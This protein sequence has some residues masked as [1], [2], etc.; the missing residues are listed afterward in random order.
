MAS[1][2][3]GEQLEPL[4]LSVQ[5]EMHVQLVAQPIAA[6]QRRSL[7]STGS[8]GAQGAGG[9][10]QNPG[11]PAAAEVSLMPTEAPEQE[12]T[13]SPAEPSVSSRKYVAGH[14]WQELP[15]GDSSSPWHV[16]VHTVLV[17]SANT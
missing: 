6:D 12:L 11:P 9:A 17:A 13:Q 10:T 14:G 16:S 5:P 1:Q 3:S 4:T 2:G 15:L 8:G 7:A